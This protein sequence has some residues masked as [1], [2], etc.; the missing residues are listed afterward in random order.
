MLP[1]PGT[2]RLPHVGTPLCHLHNRCQRLP[3]LAPSTLW[4]TLH[5]H[6]FCASLAPP[7]PDRVFRNDIP[8]S[9]V[10]PFYLLPPLRLPSRPLL[11]IIYTCL[12]R[13]RQQ[14]WRQ[15]LLRRMSPAVAKDPALAVDPL[16]EHARGLFIPLL[17]RR[18]RSLGISLWT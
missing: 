13:L 9:C 16:H 6:L 7:R 10:L 3:N 15:H 8:C 4:D 11:R 12:P 5:V 18:Q 14:P 1:T 2:P 17:L